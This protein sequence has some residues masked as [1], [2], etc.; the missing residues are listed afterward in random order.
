MNDEEKHW[1]VGKN[2]LL[3]SWGPNV[4]YGSGWYLDVRIEHW[5]A[6]KRGKI[7]VLGLAVAR[8]AAGDGHCHCA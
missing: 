7:Q 6:Y 2:D 5:A 8:V 3:P 4:P 1:P